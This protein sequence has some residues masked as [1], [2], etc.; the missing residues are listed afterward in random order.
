L[1][2][3]PQKRYTIPQLRKDKWFLRSHSTLKSKS[4]RSGTSP[5]DGQTIKRYCSSEGSTTPLSSKCQNTRL[6]SSQPNPYVNPDMD[7]NEGEIEEAKS[8]V[9]FSQPHRIEDML[10]S[11]IASTPGSSQNPFSHLIKR[12]TRFNVSLGLDDGVKTLS[13]ILEKLMLQYKVMSH[14]Q[15]RITTVDKRKSTLTYLV[16]FIIISQL[17]LLLDFRMS[18]GDGI[19]FKRQ[20]KSIKEQM[21]DYLV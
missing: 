13:K 4:P 7:E 18:K 8:S 19:E 14:N 5:R 16:N 17:P 12:M 10:L 1:H 20:F 9:F 15:V 21:K 11:Q 6:S 3:L 2:P